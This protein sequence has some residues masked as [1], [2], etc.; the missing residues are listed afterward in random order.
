MTSAVKVKDL[1]LIFSWNEALPNPG[2]KLI[3][4]GDV[5][6]STVKKYKRAVKVHRK[7]LMRIDFKAERVWNPFIETEEGCT[8][9]G[10]DG[11]IT[12]SSCDKMVPHSLKMLRLLKER[13]PTHKS[14]VIIDLPLNFR[15]SYDGWFKEGDKGVTTIYFWMN[16][17]MGNSFICRKTA[18]FESGLEHISRALSLIPPLREGEMPHHES[19]VLARVFRARAVQN[20]GDISGALAEYRVCLAAIRLLD[21]HGKVDMND[22]DHILIRKTTNFTSIIIGLTIE[23]KI[24]EGGSRPYFSHDERLDLMKEL[25]IG[26]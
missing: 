21:Y 23:S 10:A 5:P 7:D 19:E 17:R 6:A 15:D 4:I 13:I 26:M 12:R 18:D 22:P 20:L 3:N 9:L 25:G 1:A 11:S 14:K 2:N 16:Y 24:Q 8:V